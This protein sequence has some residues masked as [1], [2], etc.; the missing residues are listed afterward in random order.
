[1]DG[2]SVAE[3]LLLLDNLSDAHDACVLGKYHH[4]PGWKG[5]CIGD[6]AA[7]ISDKVLRVVAFQVA[8]C[9]SEIN[10][11]VSDAVLQLLQSGAHVG[12][13]TET[14][15]HTQDRHT[16]IV[17]AFKLLVLFAISHNAAPRAGGISH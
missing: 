10:E 2:E 8:G 3:G 6:C 4:V 5:M 1:M 13:F 12:I 11:W 15:V 7:T 14:R 16:R 9:I 17:N